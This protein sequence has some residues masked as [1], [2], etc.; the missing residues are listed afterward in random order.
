MKSIGVLIVVLAGTHLPTASAYA[1]SLILNQTEQEAAMLH[2][3]W[4]PAKKTD[5][6]NRVSGNEAAIE[7]GKALFGSTALSSSGE[8][9]CA[10]CHQ[11]GNA[12]TDGLARAIAHAELDRNTQSLWNVSSHRWFSWDGRNDNLWAQ[13]LLPIPR[14]DEMALA[15]GNL[16]AVL[17]S[18]SFSSDYA[19]IFGPPSTHSEEENLVNVGKA[20]A[21]YI[22]TLNTGETPFDNF[23]RALA[24]NDIE[25]ASQYPEAAQRGFQIF[26]G[27]GKCTF[28]HSGPLFSNG[29]FH[30]AGVPYFVEATRV[31]MGRHGG[32]EALLESPFTLGGGYTDDVAK[33]GAWKVNQ[34]RRTHNDFGTFRVPSLREVEKTAPYMHNGSLPTLKSVVDH[35]SNIDL[36][37]LHED[38]ELILE[39]LN[40]T[41]QETA[42]L[43]AF[44]KSLTAVQQ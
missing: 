27:K 8:L 40:L 42:D 13:S 4:P 33:Q 32:I 41:D 43:V 39:P 15:A 11:P 2:G 10:S 30:D 25:V 12:F 36:E 14:T 20:L 9:S 34:L 3:P 1:Q 37:R 21:A 31:D 26:S 5:P 6:S 22:E 24:E 19:K 17:T 38:G 7:L 28:C 29:E 16:E 35:Y 18:E 44:L 23:L